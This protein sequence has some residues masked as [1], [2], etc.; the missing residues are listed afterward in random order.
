MLMQLMDQLREQVTTDEV[1]VMIKKFNPRLSLG[2]NRQVMREES[3]A[4]YSC[5][6]DDDDLLSPL[7]ISRIL[8]LL[9]GVDQVGFNVKCFCDQAEIG[10]AYHSIKN[11]NWFETPRNGRH[12]SKPGLFRDISHINPIKRELALKCKMEGDV[13]EDCRWANEMRKLGIVKTE[14]Y[15]DE[16]LYFYLWRGK[17]NDAIDHQNPFRLRMIETLKRP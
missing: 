13:G 2:Q 5:F 3:T 12:G 10:I 9:D 8:P 17:K 6:I 1:G 11:A 15:V 7:Y 16:I 14:H 4:P